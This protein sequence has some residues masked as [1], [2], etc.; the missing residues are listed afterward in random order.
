MTLLRLMH[1]ALAHPW[2]RLSKGIAP[3]GAATVI[4]AVI[5]LTVALGTGLA[6]PSAAWAAEATVRA[7][8]RAEPARANFFMYIPLLNANWVDA[9]T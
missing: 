1:L 9:Q 3:H 6:L 4:T 7:A 2:A 8:T 5:G